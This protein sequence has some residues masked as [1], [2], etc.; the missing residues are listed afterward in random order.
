MLSA[1]QQVTLGKHYA[2]GSYGGLLALLQRQA[3]RAIVNSTILISKMHFYIA[4][5]PLL[6]WICCEV[7]VHMY[8]LITVSICKKET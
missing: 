4:F 8:N 3:Q 2:T 6:N 1:P 5:W 7:D